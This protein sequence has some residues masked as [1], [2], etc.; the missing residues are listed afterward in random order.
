M[1][2]EPKWIKNETMYDTRKKYPPNIGNL[3]Y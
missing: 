1:K 2:N 3:E